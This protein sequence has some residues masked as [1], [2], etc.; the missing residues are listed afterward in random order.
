MAFDPL[1]AIIEGGKTVL[2]KI[3]PDKMSES[4]KATI[5]TNYELQ[6]TKLAMTGDRNF[7]NFVLGYEGTAKDIPKGLVWIR[8]AIRPAFTIM[9]G[10]ID[11]LYFASINTFTLEQSSL[12]KAINIIVLGFWF[13]EKAL[14]RS[15]IIDVLK[16]KFTK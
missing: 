13:G 3:L 2:N 6:M 15:G 14:Q 16:G 7:R 12:L 1:T 4:E 11:Y 10:Y 5:S 8:S 9:V